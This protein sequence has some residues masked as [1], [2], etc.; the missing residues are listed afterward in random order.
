MLIFGFRVGLPKTR[1]DKCLDLFGLKRSLSK[2][3]PRCWGVKP[4]SEVKAEGGWGGG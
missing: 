2:A 4:Y 1:P 3:Q